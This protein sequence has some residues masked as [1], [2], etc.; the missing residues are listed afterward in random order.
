MACNEKRA[1]YVDT[2]VLT[3]R[4]CEYLMCVENVLPAGGSSIAHEP[5][6]CSARCWRYPP[7]HCVS[8]VHGMWYL[9]ALHES[10]Q[11][12]VS[13][14]T[15]AQNLQNYLP[16]NCNDGLN[17]HGYRRD[18]HDSTDR[19]GNVRVAI[20]LLHQ[21]CH[22]RLTNESCQNSNHETS[23]GVIIK[24]EVKHYIAEGRGTAGK[25]DHTRAGCRRHGRVYPFLNE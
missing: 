20:V 25:E 3:V 15:K 6:T 22:D 19:K 14:F 2:Y 16:S 17:G 7:Q 10:N 18:R 8:H 13:I 12:Y 9:I 4:A 5:V 21:D 24:Q 23:G 1:R 11:T